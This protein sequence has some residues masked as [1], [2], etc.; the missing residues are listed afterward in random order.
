MISRRYETEE[1]ALHCFRRCEVHPILACRS[2]NARR[3]YALGVPAS[4]LFAKDRRQGSGG[5]LGRRR[6]AD[7]GKQGRSWHGR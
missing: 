4:G 3:K 1:Q 5:R 2:G 6:G 7:Y